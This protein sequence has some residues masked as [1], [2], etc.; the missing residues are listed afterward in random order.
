MAEDSW[1]V[2]IRG[3]SKS[4]G[5]KR[6][7]ALDDVSLTIGKGEIVSI[8]GKNGAGK[9]TLVKLVTGLVYPTSDTIGVFDTTEYPRTTCLAYW[10]SSAYP[11][12][13]FQIERADS[14]MGKEEGCYLRRL[15]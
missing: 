6:F 1:A 3:V 15:F 4:Y 5:R 11:R 14:H 2:E 10:T 8:I 9:T 12:D 7:S 13:F